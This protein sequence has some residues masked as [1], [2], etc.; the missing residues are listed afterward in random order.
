[1]HLHDFIKLY[2][3]NLNCLTSFHLYAISSVLVINNNYKINSSFIKELSLNFIGLL[4]ESYLMISRVLQ[5]YYLN[6]I[7]IASN[8]FSSLLSS[9]F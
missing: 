2:M 8:L 6:V 9:T 1:M 3:I 7:N 4:E 5:K